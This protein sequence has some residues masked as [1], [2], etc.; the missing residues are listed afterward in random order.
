KLPQVKASLFVTREKNAK[1]IS[2]STTPLVGNTQLRAS[3]T[4]EKSTSLTAP[5]QKQVLHTTS[6]AALTP[7]AQTL[8]SKAHSAATFACVT[9]PTNQN[10]SGPPVTPLVHSTSTSKS[11]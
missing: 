3:R 8:F 9:P 11:A 1:S 6:N 10:K 7:L 4:P 2:T 5:K